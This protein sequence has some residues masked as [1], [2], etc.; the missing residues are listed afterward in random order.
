VPGYLLD[1]NTQISCPHGGSLTVRPRGT[2]VTLRDQG[3]FTLDDFSG[4]APVISGCQFYMGNVPSPCMHVK[5]SMEAANVEIDG[6]PALLSTSV[7]ECRTAA[8]ATQ[9]TA[10]VSGF[11]TEVEGS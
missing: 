7:G 9:G 6:S 10:L 5:W 2:S 8:Q 4:P 1:A 3:A 11:Q